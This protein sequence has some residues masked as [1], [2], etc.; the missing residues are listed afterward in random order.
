MS[1]N[2]DSRYLLRWR[3]LRAIQKQQPYLKWGI[4][5]QHKQKLI[6]QSNH[7]FQLQFSI[8]IG[9]FVVIGLSWLGTNYYQYKAKALKAIAKTYAQFD[10][11]GDARRV[12]EQ[13]TVQDEKAMSLAQVLTIWAEKQ[14]PEL[15]SENSRL[16]QS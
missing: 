16:T 9:L 12:S 2:C 5:R 11:W 13:I 14:H 10:N 1:N 4:N 6:T 8:A 15:R 3:E 7:H